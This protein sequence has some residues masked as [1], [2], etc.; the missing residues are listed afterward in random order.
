M[1]P[2]RVVA[3]GADVGMIE[4]V[5]NAQTTAKITKVK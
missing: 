5:M 3:T 2:Y 4:V 1:S